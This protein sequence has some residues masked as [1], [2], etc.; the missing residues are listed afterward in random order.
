MNEEEILE[1]G[2]KRENEERR[3]GGCSVVFDP[4]TKKYAVY[5]NQKNDIFGLFGGGFNEFEDEKD[6]C[7]RELVEESGLVDYF[8]IEKLD[9]VITHFFNNNKM[10]NRVAY[11]TCYLVVLNSLKK[12]ETRLEEHE[13]DFRFILASDNEILNNWKS[14]NSN[15]DYDHWIYFLEKANKRL[16]EL[17]HI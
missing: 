6:G 9:K 11:S 15:K 17:G 4:E 2:I 10:I 7:L 5:K 12:E 1:F 8:Y 14:N 3:D 13:S 16:K